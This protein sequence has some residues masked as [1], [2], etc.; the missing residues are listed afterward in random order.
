[1]LGG[2]D[3]MPKTQMSDAQVRNL[4]HELKRRL[5]IKI[6]YDLFIAMDERDSLIHELLGDL[7]CK[8]FPADFEG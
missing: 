7:A 4:F 6:L 1:M 8:N 5:P 3:K 2:V